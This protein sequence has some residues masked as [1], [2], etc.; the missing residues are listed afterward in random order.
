MHIGLTI[1][2]LEHAVDRATGTRA[3]HTSIPKI[4][5]GFGVSPE[6]HDRMTATAQEC[7]TNMAELCRVAIAFYL[8]HL[9]ESSR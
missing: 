6:L 8:D 3:I 7:G 5:V 2:N 1:E 4:P 9:E